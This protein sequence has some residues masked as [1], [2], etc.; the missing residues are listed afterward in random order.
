[1]QKKEQDSGET[2]R[3]RV[4]ETERSCGGE[5]ALAIKWTIREKMWR[6]CVRLISKVI[7]MLLLMLLPQFTSFFF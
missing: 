5:V 1:M 4:I 6:K 3:K 7:N 2:E